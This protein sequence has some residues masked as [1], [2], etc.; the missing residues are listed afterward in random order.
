MLA[1]LNTIATNMRRTIPRPAVKLA[2]EVK[3]WHGLKPNQFLRNLDNIIDAKIGPHNLWVVHH[4]TPD[5]A[6]LALVGD[7]YELELSVKHWAEHFERA[8]KPN[9]N[10]PER[11]WFDNMEAM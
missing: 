3:S 6:W 2:R 4:V 11:V 5:G 8:R 10:T 1:T 9:K 7:G